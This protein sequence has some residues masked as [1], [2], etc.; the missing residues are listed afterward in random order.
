MPGAHPASSIASVAPRPSRAL[1]IAIGAGLVVGVLVGLVIGGGDSAAEVEPAPAEVAE[2]TTPEPPTPTPT[3]TPAPVV[4]PTVEALPEP[5]GEPEPEGD[6]EP[7][8]EPIA[9]AETPPEPE[10]EPDRGPEP[11][12]GN[13]PSPELDRDETRTTSILLSFD[14]QPAS[15]PEL[16]I[17]VDGQKVTGSSHALTITGQKSVKIVARA[18]GYRTWSKTLT[19][20]GDKSI[21][22]KLRRPTK[23]S[24]GPG[25][26][27]DL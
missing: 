26:S 8:A 20:R 23:T 11:D 16:H 12:T 10:P 9:V 4:E 19:V 22:I 17:T 27:L 14:V 7:V 13:D 1:H 18:R 21:D 24:G 25:G 2:V 15:A 5:E 3:P 6:P